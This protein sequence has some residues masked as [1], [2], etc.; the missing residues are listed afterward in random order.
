MINWYNGIA[1]LQVLLDHQDFHYHTT[2]SILYD[3]SIHT[4]SNV[5]TTILYQL[6]YQEL[7]HKVIHSL[8]QPITVEG[9]LLY[10]VQTG[11]AI[12]VLLSEIDVHIRSYRRKISRYQASVSS[13]SAIDNVDVNLGKS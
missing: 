5:N 1:D 6:K 8:E 11:R 9:Q 2:G 3:L 13:S 7:Y 4:L 10:S 12:A